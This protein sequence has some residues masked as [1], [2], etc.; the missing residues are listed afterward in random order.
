[1][2]SGTRGNGATCL[3]NFCMIIYKQCHYSKGHRCQL[4]TLGHPGL[5]HIFNFWHSGTLALR[6]ERQSA[7]M[8]K[9]KNV[10][11]GQTCMALN[12][13]KCNHASDAT[14]LWRVNLFGNLGHMPLYWNA[15]WIISCGLSTRFLL[16]DIYVLKMP[17]R[18]KNLCAN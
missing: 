15:R 8:S 7:R 17:N 3:P 10:Y 18:G 5:T 14:A 4:V 13:F 16:D 12:N 6:A 9:I 11:I 2:G 1:M